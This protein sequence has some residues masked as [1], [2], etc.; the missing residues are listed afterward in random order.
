MVFSNDNL[1]PG[2]QIMFIPRSQT[3]SFSSI[4]DTD[5]IKRLKKLT[6]SKKMKLK[7]EELL[8][9]SIYYLNE[10]LLQ[11]FTGTLISQITSLLNIYPQL[12]T[13]SVLEYKDKTLNLLKG[14]VIFHEVKEAQTIMNSHWEVTKPLFHNLAYKN[15]LWAYHNVYTKN[16]VFN[17]EMLMIPLID[18]LPPDVPGNN[19]TL[20]EYDNKLDGFR[21]IANK[22]ILKNRRIFNSYLQHNNRELLIK[23][24]LVFENNVLDDFEIYLFYNDFDPLINI[25][26]SILENKDE[27][28]I[29]RIKNNF[30]LENI[31]L[32]FAF[33]RVIE[34]T[35]KLDLKDLGFYLRNAISLENE[36]RVLKKLELIFRSKLSNYETDC[37][38]DEKLLLSKKISIN[39]RNCV[40]VSNCEK[41][42]INNF[43]HFIT[44]GQ[45]YL[46]KSLMITSQNKQIYN[47]I[48]G[49]LKIIDN[50]K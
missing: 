37:S 43:I 22:T 17:N 25:K 36:M 46:T 20:L 10:K 2:D 33:T 42:I 19:Q 44:L 18:L 30:K 12:F 3:Y 40:F 32:L 47:D 28:F 48:Q 38:Q 49:Y 15:F 24:G 34:A 14:S 8:S 7:N 21:L 9:L 31:G 45:K 11:N 1:N 4:Q 13:T 23:Y 35:N 6:T 26:K 27:P 41:K 50:L 16:I 39:E 29:F 5:I